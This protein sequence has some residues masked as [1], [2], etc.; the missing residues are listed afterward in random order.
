V[1]DF[2]SKLVCSGNTQGVFDH[3]IFNIERAAY[4]VQ[5]WRTFVDFQQNNSQNFGKKP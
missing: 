2:V 5:H 1:A 4:Q 3:F